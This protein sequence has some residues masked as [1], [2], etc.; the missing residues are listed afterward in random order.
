[1]KNLLII[2]III[3]FTTPLYAGK[4]SKNSLPFGFLILAGGHYDDMRMCIASPAGTKGGAVA[5][6]MLITRLR[7]TNEHSLTFNLP[8]L[9]PLIFSSAFKMLQFNPEF[10]FEITAPINKKMDFVHGPAL[11]ANFHY[12]PDYKSDIYNKGASFFAAGPSIGYFA[13]IGFNFPGNYYSI[14]A[15]R[16]FYSPLF[17]EGR[18][19]GTIAGA[20]V[21]YTMYF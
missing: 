7:F 14:I 3:L 12:G 13:G 16:I 5:D 1:M 4:H 10:R 9:R 8:I 2:A 17:S 15:I 21:E 6:I 20:G 19:L 18:T 11:G